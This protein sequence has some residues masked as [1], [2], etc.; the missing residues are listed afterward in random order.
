MIY[1]VIIPFLVGAWCLFG[2]LAWPDVHSDS[3][4]HRMMNGS[5]KKR[6]KMFV[7]CFCAMGPIFVLLF[8][9]AFLVDRASNIISQVVRSIDEKN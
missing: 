1:L 4:Y 5:L 8:A 7:L 9:F 2:L 6:F 3:N